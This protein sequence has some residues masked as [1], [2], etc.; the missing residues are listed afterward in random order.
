MTRV[1]K[2]IVTTRR[3]LITTLADLFPGNEA[4]FIAR[5]ILEHAGYS[6]YHILKDPSAEPDLQSRSKIKKIVNELQKNRPIQYILGETEFFNLHF[7]VDERVL[8]PRPETEELVNHIL[9]ENK[10]AAPRI[11]DVGTG[12]GCIAITLAHYISGSKVTAMDS[13]PGA[14]EVAKKNA[15]R[16]NARVEFLLADILE[17]AGNPGYH[18]YDLVVSNPPYVTESEKL[19]MHPRVTTHE[20]AAALYVSNEDPLIF[21]R[22]IATYGKSALAGDGSVWVEINERFGKE[23]MSVFTNEGYGSVRLLK[24]IHGKDR[25][26]K[27]TKK[28]SEL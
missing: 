9:Q 7:I 23:T 12:S 11:L 16:N 10:S 28:N 26:I 5:M 25:F 24:D 20:P 19:E 6:E 22:A 3:E 8:I 2:D 15:D 17:M 4:V 1:I 13:E 14:I 18:R 27:A 21:Y